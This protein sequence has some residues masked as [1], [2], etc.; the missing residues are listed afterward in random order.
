MKIRKT[1]EGVVVT[2]QTIWRAR[3]GRECRICD[4]ATDHLI[5]AVGL[6]WRSVA[7]HSRG[8]RVLSDE[9]ARLYNGAP[10]KARKV[11][12]VMLQVIAERDRS[13]A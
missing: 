12:K 11:I 2:P 9:E 7:I 1:K 6:I 4:M 5:N 8:L 13:G 10:E 3:D